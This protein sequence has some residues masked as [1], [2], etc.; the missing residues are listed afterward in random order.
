MMFRVVHPCL[1]LDIGQQIKIV[2]NQMRLSLHCWI[3]LSKDR[4]KIIH[5]SL[6]EL[7]APSTNFYVTRVWH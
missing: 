5:H 3:C 1:H 2:S 7:K 4:P 6:M